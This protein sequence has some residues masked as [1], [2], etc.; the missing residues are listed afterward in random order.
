[1]RCHSLHCVT[2][3]LR[4]C[5]EE[6]DKY[7]TFLW[8]VS[9]VGLTSVARTDRRLYGDTS[10]PTSSTVRV[11]N[12]ITSTATPTQWHYPIN[13]TADRGGTSRHC[14]KTMSSS[15]RA[16]FGDKVVAVMELLTETESNCTPWNSRMVNDETCD[17]WR[18][19]WGAV[20]C[21]S[22]P[23]ACFEPGFKNSLVCQRRGTNIE[24]TRDERLDR[25]LALN[26]KDW[27]ITPASSPWL[28][29]I[30]VMRYPH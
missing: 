1:M 7:C 4:W 24:K 20:Y 11:N 16:I 29:G 27:Y 23:V 25:C 18:Y 22:F 12:G 30:T 6:V 13:Y 3:L 26:L 5:N 15:E 9:W 17:V 10:L 21:S 14:A 19:S 2:I 8:P 28:W